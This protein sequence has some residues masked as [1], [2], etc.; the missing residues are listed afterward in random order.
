MYLHHVNTVRRNA[1]LV[2]VG[3]LTKQKNTGKKGRRMC[4]AGKNNAE[5]DRR[6][7][8]QDTRTFTAKISLVYT[9][10]LRRRPRGRIQAIITL[11]PLSHRPWSHSAFPKSNRPC[12]GT[13]R[14]ALKTE[15]M[16]VG[17]VSDLTAA[18]RPCC[19]VTGVAAATAA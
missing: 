8:P 15:E 10:R 12:G 1:N 16:R 17:P 14:R 2:A 11:P 18:R 9:R 7:E 5:T 6:S 13:K 19:G 4:N 3:R